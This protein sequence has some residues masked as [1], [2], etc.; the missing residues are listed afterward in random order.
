MKTKK[1]NR[2]RYN[3]DYYEENREKYLETQRR[4]RERNR[5]KAKE[6]NNRYYEENR[7]ILLAAKKVRYHLGKELA[8]DYRKEEELRFL[9]R[10]E[11]YFKDIP[12]GDT[13]KFG[14][15]IVRL[16]NLRDLG[17]AR[18]IFRKYV[19]RK[20]EKLFIKHGA[21][22]SGIFSEDGEWERSPYEVIKGVI[23]E[24]DK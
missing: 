12:D 13:R 1:V 21:P 10:L 16:Y 3:K 11:R 5:D 15:H 17:Q 2:K 24:I 18:L 9:R 8:K 7:E 14:V 23:E 22:L 4:W 19:T 20:G 6:Y